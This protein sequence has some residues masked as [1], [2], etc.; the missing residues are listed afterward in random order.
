MQI[1]AIPFVNASLGHVEGKG[2]KK[3]SVNWI[4]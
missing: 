3:P 2:G 1:Q 4:F